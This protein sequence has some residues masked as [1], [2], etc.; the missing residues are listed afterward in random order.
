[1]TRSELITRM[2]QH[3]PQLLIKDIEISVK[4]ILEQ[5]C[6]T[7]VTGQRIEIRRFGSFGVSYRPPRIGR[8]PK[9]GESVN[10]SGKYTPYFRAG[11]EM[12][13]R[14]DQPV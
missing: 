10:V 4:E 7:I 6:Q 11:K 12:R 14:V 9:T 3:F 1:M 13:A 8:N 2:A 5:L